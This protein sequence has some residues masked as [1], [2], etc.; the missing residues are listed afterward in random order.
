M[1]PHKSQQAL[2][3]CFPHMSSA[4]FLYFSDYTKLKLIYTLAGPAKEEPAVEPWDCSPSPM[5]VQVQKGAHGGLHASTTLQL[6]AERK[7]RNQNVSPFCSW[8]EE[9]TGT[10]CAAHFHFSGTNSWLWSC[11][12]SKLQESWER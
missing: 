5:K 7:G 11:F 9:L 1:P 10:R 12:P 4:A 6:S 3:R 2:L 8:K